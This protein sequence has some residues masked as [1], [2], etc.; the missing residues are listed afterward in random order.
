PPTFSRPAGVP[1]L[2]PAFPARTSVRG[3]WV[4]L[5]VPRITRRA[6]AVAVPGV[7]GRGPLPRTSA[8]WRGYGKFGCPDSCRS[9][10]LGSASH[11]AGLPGPFLGSAVLLDARR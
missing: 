10:Q 8:H 6:L 11:F 2:P 1:S 9:A 7:S 5:R 4:T 3:G